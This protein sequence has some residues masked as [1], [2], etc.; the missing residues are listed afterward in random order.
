MIDPWWPLPDLWPQQCPTLWSGALLT[1]FGSHRAFL[2][3][4]DLW[5]TFDPRSGRF[6]NVPT[7]LMGPSPTPMQ[8]FSSIPQS[9]AKRIAGHIYTHIHRLH[10]F[11]NI[12][13]CNPIRSILSNMSMEQRQIAYSWIQFNSGAMLAALQW[14]IAATPLSGIGLF[15]IRLFKSAVFGPTFNLITR[16]GW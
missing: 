7:N 6:E 3:H 5:M 11:S 13:V 14:A 10:Y 1:K 4:I 16:E 9:M 2:R 15:S 12:D 8:S